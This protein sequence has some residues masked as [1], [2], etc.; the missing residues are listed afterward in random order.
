[1]DQKR[2]LERG[3]NLVEFAFIAPVLLLIL[4]AILDFGR[5]VYAYSVVASAAREGARYGI[6]H[7]D[8]AAAIECAAR[9]TAVALD[10]NQLSILVTLPTEEQ[11]TVEVEVTY[12][13]KLIT[14][15]VAEAIG[16]RDSL[17]LRSTASMY[18]GF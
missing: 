4:L 15:L 8:D 10:P 16:G 9:D 2:R 18:T 5:A 3:S 12:A 7:R 11:S 14:P 1:M 6:I 13:F 17:L